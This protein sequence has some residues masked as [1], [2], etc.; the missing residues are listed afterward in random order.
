MLL[1]FFWPECLGLAFGVMFR[2]A[3]KAAEV[4]PLLL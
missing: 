2:V 1:R 4:V 3:N